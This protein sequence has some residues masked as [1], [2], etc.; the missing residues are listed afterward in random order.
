MEKHRS[1]FSQKVNIN[2]GCWLWKGSLNSKGYGNFSFN[3]KKYNAH[4]AA[5]I[6]FVDDVP[7]HIDIC[8]SCDNRQCVN[9]SHLF[10]GT[11]QDNIRDAINKKRFSWN[12]KPPLL[13]SKAKEEI[14]KELKEGIFHKEISKK[15][16]V[17]RQAIT[18]INILR[19]KD[20]TNGI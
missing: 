12:L 9:P 11:R 2:D 13:S 16:N 15:H 19:K 5:Y 17:S 4:R 8:H 18:R 10:A 1:R 7:S 6:L 14:I 20:V 3:K